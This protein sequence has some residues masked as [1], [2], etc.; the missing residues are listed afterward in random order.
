[1]SPLSKNQSRHPPP[2]FFFL[3]ETAPTEIYTLSLHDALPISYAGEVTVPRKG[4]VAWFGE[5]VFAGPAGPFSLSTPSHIAPDPVSRNA[6]P[7]P[8]AAGNPSPE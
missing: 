8:P 6:R 7:E 3:S 2:V 1:M 5:L 4:S